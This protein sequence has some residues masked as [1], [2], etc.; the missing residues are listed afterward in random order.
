MASALP[1]SLAGRAGSLSA[2]VRQGSVSQ[3]IGSVPPAQRGA[4][5]LA[6]RSSF[7]SALNE[8][9]YVTAAVAL[10]GAV[11]ATLLIRRK[12]LYVPGAGESAGAGHAAA[13][14]TV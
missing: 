4:V 9:L 11:C 13:Q 5:A 12:D 7:A 1:S 3:L 10:V 14:E 6:L 8:L 2:A